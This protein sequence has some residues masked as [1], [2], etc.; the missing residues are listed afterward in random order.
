V[1]GGSFVSEA[2]RAQVTFYYRLNPLH[3]YATIGFR[4]VHVPNGH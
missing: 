4:L 2:D 3:R 1:R